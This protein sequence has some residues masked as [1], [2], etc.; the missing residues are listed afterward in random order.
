MNSELDADL[1]PANA[2]SVALRSDRPKQ[3]GI[4]LI[5]GSKATF[6]SWE[7]AF[8]E[9]KHE[10]L[11]EMYWFEDDALGAPFIE[12]LCA[13]AKEGVQVRLI[14][15]S[16]GSANAGR[17]AFRPIVEA[18]G[19][20]RE[21]HS[22][23][24]WRRGFSFRGIAQRDHRKLVVVD[25]MVGFV[26]GVNLT[27]IAA[28]REWGGE[29]WLD[30]AAMVTGRAA[31]DLKVL[32]YMT[33][34][35]LNPK[36]ARPLPGME[37]KKEVAMD[38]MSGVTV[39]ASHAIRRTYLDRIRKARSHILIANAYFIPDPSVR[40]ALRKAARRGVDV[41]ILV[42]EHS[43]VPHAAFAS[44]GTYQGLMDAGVHVHHWVRNFLHSKVAVID[45][46]GTVGSYNLDYQSWRFNLEV[47]VMSNDDP[48]VDELERRMRSD[49]ALSKEID[50]AVWK[51]RPV[52]EKVLEWFFYQ[53]RKFM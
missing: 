14:Y 35:H 42:P 41:R 53:F 40:R 52:F 33:W 38:V 21:F 18:G 36:R 49:L 10:I 22:I 9:A 17:H 50:P 11:C 28:P 39:R 1:A 48:F 27:N 44:K 6:E 46:W 20:V 30:Y 3:S 31:H 47:N 29:D 13:R 34:E 23:Y 51:K 37:K 12:L 7:R 8:R 15:D 43:D 32:F 19:E 16:F 25:G 45:R 26:G 4:R 24:P 5:S 2:V